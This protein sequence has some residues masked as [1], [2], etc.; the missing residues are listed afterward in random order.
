MTHI[1]VTRIESKG[2]NEF[3]NLSSEEKYLYLIYCSNDV[4]VNGSQDRILLCEFRVKVC[5]F[6]LAFLKVRIIDKSRRY[7]HS[8]QDIIIVKIFLTIFGL[9][10]GLIL[11]SSRSF[12]LTSLKKGWCLIASSPPWF[13]KEDKFIKNKFSPNL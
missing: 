5:S 3:L 4:L 10:G 12:H 7:N 9:K 11:L 6:F 13:Y 2:Q 8:G 1:I